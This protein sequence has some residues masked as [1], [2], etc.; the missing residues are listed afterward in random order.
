MCLCYSDYHGFI[1]PECSEVSGCSLCTDKLRPKGLGNVI[2]SRF[3]PSAHFRSQQE[4]IVS[5]DTLPT[6]EKFH[7]IPSSLCSLPP[8]S[9]KNPRHTQTLTSASVPS[10][11]NPNPKMVLEST[12]I[13]YV[14]PAR[15]FSTLRQRRGHAS[16]SS[17]LPP[18][19]DYVLACLFFGASG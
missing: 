14:S 5:G 15:P 9:Y 19:P 16:C 1:R 11:K 17:R 18:P 12:M 7:P 4:K 13:M 2:D 3:G 6:H 8:P 10:R